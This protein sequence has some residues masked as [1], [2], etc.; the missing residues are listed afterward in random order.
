MTSDAQRFAVAPEL[1]LRP[2]G[3]IAFWM[4]AVLEL[5]H[6]EGFNILK[7]TFVGAGMLVFSGV[8]TAGVSKIRWPGSL[9]PTCLLLALAFVLDVCIGSTVLF[10]QK[11][12]YFEWTV[13]SFVVEIPRRMIV[14]LV[15]LFGAQLQLDRAEGGGIAMLC[16]GIVMILILGCVLTMLS[17]VLISLNLVTVSADDL[18]RFTG[19]YGTPGLAALIGCLTVACASAILI[20]P[21]S[22]VLACVGLTAGLFSVIMSFRKTSFICILVVILFFLLFGGPTFRRRFIAWVLVACIAAV[23]AVWASGPGSLVFL[24][25]PENIIRTSQIL[26]LSSGDISS[27]N[28]FSGRLELWELGLEEFFESPLYGLGFDA[29]K[30]MNNASYS[31]EGIRHGP[32]NSYIKHAAE[33]GVVPIILLLIGLTSLFQVQWIVPQSPGRN[34]VVASVMVICLFAISDQRMFLHRISVFHLGV[35]VEI[36]KREIEK[37]RSAA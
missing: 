2:L 33:S 14:F 17:P 13:N 30:H 22:L 9:S 11:F 21:K 7:G 27:N 20:E 15:A 23:F 37:Q 36:A 3:L 28:A 12:Q 18:M 32:H 5:L 8:V 34:F 24:L 35:I 25:K 26:D 19:V 10:F 16:R 6:L 4:V 29:L 1:F 31:V